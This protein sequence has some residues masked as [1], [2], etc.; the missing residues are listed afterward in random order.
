[1]G[2]GP[3]RRYAGRVLGR[4]LGIRPEDQ[5]DTI[6][7]FA[8]LV[9]MLAAHSM[10]ET[11]RD[12]LF[13]SKLPASY[14]P[15]TYIVIA[16]LALV[17]SR[18]NSAAAA[19]FSRKRLLSL[20]LL[21]GGVATLAF[22]PAT[23]GRDA[24]MLGALYVWTGLC[25]T[26]VV[27]QFWLLLGDVF[28]VTQAKRLFSIIG[29]GGL[30][31]ATLGSGAASLLLTVLDARALLL[32]A[33][34]LFIVAAFVPVM[35]PTTTEA[36]DPRPRGQAAAMLRPGAAQPG[37]GS[38]L[39]MC[40][41]DT[42]LLRLFLI[43]VIGAVLFTAIDYLFKA[44]MVQEAEA[45]GWQLASVFA[46][47]YAAINALSLLVQ[48]VVAPRLMRAVGV[49][50]ALLILP[51]LVLFGGA[52]LFVAA[53]IA[54]AIILKASDG[55]FRHSVHKT[56]SEILY[57]PLTRQ[58]RERFKNLAE[59][60][61]QKGGQA[62]ASLLI[63][64]VTA[65]TKDTRFIAGGIV[66]LALA[67]VMTM[68]G[69]KQHYLDLFLRQLKSGALKTEV[70][71][72][73]LDLASFEVLV[74]ALSAEDDTEVIAAL[75]MFESYGKTDLV[76]ALIL[77]HPSRDVVMRAFEMFAKSKRADVQ[78]LLGRLL[79]HE[80][81]E[82]RAAAL[83]TIATSKPDEQLLR[84]Y[85]ED[86]SPTVRTTALVAL[87]IAGY[88]DDAEADK[89]LRKMVHGACSHTRISLARALRQLPQQRF[90]WLAEELA[91]KKEVGLAA[92]VARSLAI[93]PHLDQ[94][95]LLL[96]LLELR[97]SRNDARRA[98][99]AL[100]DE[101]LEFVG[102][103][104][105]DRELP[106][107]LRLHLPR[108]VSRFGTARAAEIL[109]EVLP[110]E[111]D[112]RVVFKILR[113]LG[114]MRATDADTPVDAAL[115]LRVAEKTLEM[116]I[117][118][119]YWRLAVGQVVAWKQEAMTPAAELL[120]AFLDE[121]RELAIARVFRLL[122]I[123]EPTQEFRIIH[124]ALRGKDTKS[125]ASSREL[126]ENV[127]PSPLREGILAMVDDAQPRQKL[128]AARE[129]F[130]P[131]GR[132]LFDRVMAR[133]RE[134]EDAENLRELGLV[135]ADTLR[136]MLAD[137]SLALRSI[138]GYH[139]AELGLEDLIKEVRLAQGH[140]SDALHEIAERALKPF[141]FIAE[142]EPAH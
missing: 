123:I 11:A 40:M 86:P 59:A 107:E 130:D 52:G 84:S 104:L 101:A 93:A 39:Q 65:L 25:A 117:T 63:L 35:L 95:P 126:L 75:D 2:D 120:V 122:H 80:D 131:R 112:E 100:G 90:G 9:A 135:Y 103:A 37:G 102:N 50:G 58:V 54:P 47:F 91:E 129:I 45:R 136:S 56:A 30:V 110:D 113:G 82:I 67:W 27:V 125:K 53:G 111:G 17:V 127:V 94:M 98:L 23:A 108:S 118:A 41:K 62:L 14:L 74:S 36:D 12:A 96:T 133:I 83:R 24:W 18:V 78:R 76:P 105:K 92:E 106:R 1:M 55:A 21:I 49:Q 140:Q 138:V 77:Y 142:P 34:G 121:K 48:L 70:E 141:S 10:L 66:V 97:E 71:V 33:G 124:D 99:V 29:A 87:V 13:L 26:V 128:K 57:L 60:L 16:A 69:T 132:E 15:V 64:G 44:T 42:Y 68:R 19:R 85:F 20:T 43:A 89:T 109:Q 28:N 5:R 46:H 6:V 8:T 79:R 116:A 81:A 51:V 32:A 119:L 4:L 73:D 115:L 3:G 88:I 139:V 22:Y 7:S 114:R 61:G 137:P 134:S 38:S 31:G 72:P